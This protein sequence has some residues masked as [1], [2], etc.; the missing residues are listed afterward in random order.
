MRCRKVC[1]IPDDRGCDSH[2]GTGDGICDIGTGVE[3]SSPLDPADLGGTQTAICTPGIDVV[4]ASGTNLKLR[5]QV[6]RT[7]ALPNRDIDTL[8]LVCK[9]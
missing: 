1:S 6:K 3:F 2:F 5:S 8:E 4:V 9:P 7:P